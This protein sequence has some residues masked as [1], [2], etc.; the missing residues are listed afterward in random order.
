MA[1]TQ[2]VARWPLAMANGQAPW[3]QGLWPVATAMAICHGHD[4]WPLPTGHW[5][6]PIAMASGHG[7]WP[8]LMAVTMDMAMAVTTV[9]T[10]KQP[11]T[12]GHGNVAN[13]VATAV[14]TA[15]GTSYWPCQL[16]ITNGRGYG[17]GHGSR[18]DGGHGHWLWQ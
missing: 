1:A 14:V 4:Q 3:P 17:H 10:F 11:V 13:G 16:A 6:L 9:R 8:W 2:P 5:Q 12:L 18:H 7:P 15:K